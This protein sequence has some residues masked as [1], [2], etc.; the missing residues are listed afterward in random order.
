MG[1]YNIASLKSSVQSPTSDFLEMMYDK[2]F[3]TLFLD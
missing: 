1:D 2:S 3:L